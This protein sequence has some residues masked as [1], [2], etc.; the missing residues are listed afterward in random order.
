MSPIESGSPSKETS[1]VSVPSPSSWLAEATVSRS[2]SKESFTPRERSEENS[3]TRRIA[4]WQ[5]AVATLAAR[6]LDFERI[7]S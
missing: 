1:S 4:A 2:F 3:A 6:S 5:A 7:F